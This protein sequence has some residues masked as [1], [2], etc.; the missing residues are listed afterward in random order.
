MI[1]KNINDEKLITKTNPSSRLVIW[2]VLILEVTRYSVL[3]SSESREVGIESTT[4]DWQYAGEQKRVPRVPVRSI[5]SNPLT[6]RN[7]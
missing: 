5:A 4:S 2:H 3:C 1:R 7:E 6:E